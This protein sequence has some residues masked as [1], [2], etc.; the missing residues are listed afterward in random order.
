MLKG[1][2]QYNAI[3]DRKIG[4][5]FFS[6]LLESIGYERKKIQIKDLFK[7]LLRQYF[8]KIKN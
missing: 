6:I 2:P 7:H 1:T 3:F 4:W 8:L 5:I